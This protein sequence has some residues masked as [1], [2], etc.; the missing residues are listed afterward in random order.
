MSGS[1]PE[2]VPSQLRS[3]P[4]A[5]PTG[6]IFGGC[7]SCRVL[8][9]GGLLLAAAYVY[10][11]ARKTMRLGHASMGVAAQIAFSAG[12]VSISSWYLDL[13]MCMANINSSDLNPNQ[14]S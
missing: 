11:G 5:K 8:S 14:S 9:G 6:N 2:Q 7:W 10:M 4:S 1:Q 12:D 13:V 3:D